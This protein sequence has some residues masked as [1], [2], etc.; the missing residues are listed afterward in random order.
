MNT[1]LRHVGIVIQEVEVWLDFLVKHLDFE[2]WIDQVETGSF[3]SKLI[4]IPQSTVR[5]LKLKDRYGGVI[6]LLYFLSPSSETRTNGGVKPN[7]LGLTHIALQVDSVDQKLENLSKFGLHPL[8]PA[9]VSEDG[10]AK[11]CYMYGPEKVL[12]EL[13]E[14]LK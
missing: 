9:T 4:A 14:L 10:Q 1:K 12:F 5:T 13:V 2:I 11:V 7:S 3:I 8:N 6:E